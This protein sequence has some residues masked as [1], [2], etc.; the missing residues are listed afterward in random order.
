M[1]CYRIHHWNFIDI[2]VY[3]SHNIVTIPPPCWTNAGHKH[4]VKVLGTFITEW[5]EGAR[6]CSSILDN[7]ESYQHFAKQ[8]VDIAC[9]YNFDGWLIN[10][11]NEIIVSVDFIFLSSRVDKICA[12]FANWFKQVVSLRE[13]KKLIFSLQL[14]SNKLFP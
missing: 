5:K 3:F 14:G 7:V 10:I 4:G 9:Y 6:Y 12:L 13:Y 1:N 8:L 11:E 2:F